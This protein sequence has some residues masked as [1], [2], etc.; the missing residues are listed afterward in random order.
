MKNIFCV[1]LEEWFH[2]NFQDMI[3]N[4][5]GKH[6]VRVLD[7]TYKL[8]DMFERN[9]VKATFFVLGYIAENH[10]ALINEIQKKGHEIACHG[11]AHELVYKQT[12]KE[13]KYDV[14]KSKYLIERITNEPIIGYRAPS[15]SIT[16]KSLWALEILQEI[17]MK[18]DSSIFPFENFLYGIGDAPRNSFNTNIYGENLSLLE[19]PPS[20]IQVL[21]QNIPFT[22]GFYLRALPYKLIEMGIKCV[23]KEGYPAVCYIHPREIDPQQP[24]LKLNFKENIIHNF[25]I[26]GCED[27]LEK[28]CKNNQFVSIKDYYKK[29]LL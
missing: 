11:Y 7:N 29:E 10:P 18:Y 4:S 1:D 22:G 23:N 21:G 6:K 13:F 16:K 27:K 9:T 17:G 15:W 2:S 20:T 5:P 3:D 28:L 24:H 12:P 14:E 26:N 19:I 25:G 8:L